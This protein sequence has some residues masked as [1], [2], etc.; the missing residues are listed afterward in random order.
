MSTPSIDDP[1]TDYWTRQIRLGAIIATIVTVLGIVQVTVNWTPERQWWAV[2][3][4][5]AAGMQALAGTLPWRRWVRRPRVRAWLI[6]WWVLEIPVLVVFAQHNPTGLVLYL[7]CAMLIVV[8]AAAL[9]SAAIGVGL[10]TLTLAGSLVLL[11]DAT[12]VLVVGMTSVMGSVVTVSAIM[13][14]N[15]RRLDNRRRAAERRRA[16]LLQNSPEVVICLGRDGDV[17]YA[18]PSM[19]TVLGHP[20]ATVNGAMLGTLVHPQDLAR[21]RGWI[22]ALRSSAPATISEAEAGYAGRT[23]PGRSSTS[24]ARTACTTP[25]CRP[26][27]SVCA[28]SR[29]ARRWRSSSVDRRSPTRSPGCRTGRCSVTGCSMPPPGAGRRSRSSC[30]PGQLQGR[31]RQ[32]GAQRRRRASHHYRREAAGHRMPR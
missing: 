5:A 19:H 28:T 30:R 11:S 12:T 15:R 9:Y 25:T 7:P 13:A 8:M 22:T 17:R 14:H 4:G 2:P 20:V 32:P 6:M 26:W 16:A 27:S 3:M 10:G 29:R 1:E 24:S 21:I 31:Q 18:S 23:V